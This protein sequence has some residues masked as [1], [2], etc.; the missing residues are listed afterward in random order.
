MAPDKA[1][2]PD[3]F[4][5]RFFQAAWPVI[6]HDLMSAFD[7]FWRLDT[8][9]LHSMND[10]LIV[11]LPKSAEAESMKEFR[12]IALIHSVGKI[13]AKVLANRLAPKFDRLVHANQNAFIKGRFIHDSFKLV[14]A[15]AKQL[16]ARKVVC[17]LL[18]IDIARAFDLVS[19]PFLLRVIQSMGFSRVWRN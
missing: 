5:A 1:S 11:L 6:R 10:A 2:G 12:P 9:H 18:K 8:R 3:S 15:S 16:H 14:Q 4:T 19:W 13:T 7:A 17:L